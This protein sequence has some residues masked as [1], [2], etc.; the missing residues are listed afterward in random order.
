MT[1]L[2][3]EDKM[4][5][6]NKDKKEIWFDKEKFKSV[7]NQLTK[8]NWFSPATRVE[9]LTYCLEKP[10]TSDWMK[11]VDD[12]KNFCFYFSDVLKTHLYDEKEN[13]WLENPFDDGKFC[14]A[15]FNLLNKDEFH[16]SRNCVLLLE[17]FCLPDIHTNHQNM[18]LFYSIAI[19]TMNLFFTN[20]WNHIPKP[21]NNFIDFLRKQIFLY[22]I[23]NYCT[24]FIN[25][26]LK[27]GLEP[28]KLSS[29]NWIFVQ[30]NDYD[31]Q[32]QN[33][34]VISYLLLFLDKKFKYPFECE[35]NG[36]DFIESAMNIYENMYKT[37]I[38]LPH[39]KREDAIY[40]FFNMF[41]IRFIKHIIYSYREDKTASIKFKHGIYLFHRFCSILRDDEKRLNSVL[42]NLFKIIDVEEDFVLPY[43]NAYGKWN[44]IKLCGDVGK[45][46][47][48][49]KLSSEKSI[50]DLI[51]GQILNYE[52]LLPDELIDK[53]KSHNDKN[54]P[55]LQFD[56]KQEI[57]LIKNKIFYCDEN[58]F[59]E[60]IESI[61]KI[62]GLISNKDG[63]ARKIDDIHLKDFLKL[64]ADNKF[65]LFKYVC[66]LD[67]CYGGVA[68]RGIS[69][70]IPEFEKFIIN[71][72]SVKNETNKLFLSNSN[73]NT[74]IKDHL[75]PNPYVCSLYNLIITKFIKAQTESD[76]LA[77]IVSILLEKFGSIYDLIYQVK[78]IL[79]EKN[80]G[81]KLKGLWDFALDCIL[82]V[83]KASNKSVLSL[84][85]K[86]AN[87][88][89]KKYVGQDVLE[90]GEITLSFV[91]KAMLLIDVAKAFDYDTNI[92]CEGTKSENG[93]SKKTFDLLNKII[94]DENFKL[95]F[96]LD[97]TLPIDLISI[98]KCFEQME[99]LKFEV[100]FYLNDEIFNPNVKQLEEFSPLLKK[101]ADICNE[102]DKTTIFDLIKQTEKFTQKKV[103]KMERINKIENWAKKVKNYAHEIKANNL[104]NKNLFLNQIQTEN[105]K[106]S[107]KANDLLKKLLKQVKIVTGS[108]NVGERGAYLLRS[109]LLNQYFNSLYEIFCMVYDPKQHINL[110]SEYINTYREIISDS[111]NSAIVMKI[112][113]YT[114]SAIMGLNKKN[115]FEKI[116]ELENI[117]IEIIGYII[118]LISPYS[119]DQVIFFKNENGENII[120]NV[121]GGLKQLQENLIDHKKTSELLNTDK[122]LHSFNRFER[123]KDAM[124]FGD[125]LIKKAYRKQERLLNNLYIKSGIESGRSY[126]LLYKEKRQAITD[127]TNLNVFIIRLIASLCT[128]KSID[129]YKLPID[130][131]NSFCKELHD[132]LNMLY[133]L[134][135]G[136]NR[137]SEYKNACK[138]VI[139]QQQKMVIEIS[140]FT[141]DAIR[142]LNE[143]DIFEKVYLPKYEDDEDIDI[144]TIDSII[145]L[146]SNRTQKDII[147][148]KD[149]NDQNITSNIIEEFKL[150]KTNLKINGLRQKFQDCKEKYP[151]YTC[152]L[153]DKA[154]A[155]F[156]DLHDF[157]SIL[158]EPQTKEQRIYTEVL[159]DNKNSQM[160]MLVET[161]N[162]ILNVIKILNSKEFDGKKLKDIDDQII[163][164]IIDLLS[165]DEQKTDIVFFKDEKGENITSD[166]TN[167]LKLLKTNIESYIYDKESK[168]AIEL[169][170]ELK[171]S[172][173]IIR[174]VSAEE[175]N[176][177]FDN[178]YKVLCMIYVP[179]KIDDLKSKYKELYRKT[180]SDSENLELVLTISERLEKLINNLNNQISEYV[181]NPEEIKIETIESI[182]KLF[183]V[184]RDDNVIIFKNQQEAN[185]TS[186]I[187]DKMKKLKKN[188]SQY[189]N[190]KSKLQTSNTNQNKD[191]NKIDT[192]TNKTNATDETKKIL[193]EEND[194]KN[195]IQDKNDTS[196]NDYKQNIENNIDEST[197]KF[198]TIKNLFSNGQNKSAL[199]DGNKRK[200][201][202]SFHVSHNKIKILFNEIDNQRATACIKNK[203]DSIDNVD[204]NNN[205]HENECNNFMFTENDLSKRN[206]CEEV[207][208]EGKK[209]KIETNIK[210]NNVE[211]DPNDIIKREDTNDD[212]SNNTS[213]ATEES[214]NDIENKKSEEQTLISV[215]EFQQN[216]N[217]N[218]R[219]KAESNYQTETNKNDGR[220]NLDTHNKINAIEIENDQKEINGLENEEKK[221][222][223]Q[224][225]NINANNDN[226]SDEIIENIMENINY[227][228]SEFN[229][230]KENDDNNI[231]QNESNKQIEDKNEIK[232]I[233]E[234]N[235]G[236]NIPIKND[237]INNQYEK[238]QSENNNEENSNQKENNLNLD[239]SYAIVIQK[240][241]NNESNFDKS[242]NTEMKRSSSF[243]FK[244]IYRN[245][246]ELSQQKQNIPTTT[247]NNKKKTIFAIIFGIIFVLSAVLL[248]LA[249]TIQALNFLALVISMTVVV[250]VTLIITIAFIISIL[251]RKKMLESLNIKGDLRSRSKS[252]NLLKKDN[253]ININLDNAGILGSV[254]IK[255][256]K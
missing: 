161:S 206:K 177:C 75:F 173:L 18:D 189:I 29:R 250:A 71:Y 66:K 224:N 193:N 229:D 254:H 180:I 107:R 209:N 25:S 56:I 37:F 68:I 247:P 167:G 234:S 16:L 10:V 39:K 129:N 185:I 179:E 186:D 121:V 6:K 169:L 213:G 118:G 116:D 123:V 138:E 249:L 236:I 81:Y 235:N 160:F 43:K 178:L 95:F 252:V 3:G 253:N 8:Q 85:I 80:Y 61:C 181:K 216:H 91:R 220:E 139:D 159:S 150:L 170:T 134:E 87:G 44:F 156:K 49:N 76:E 241:S 204:K 203:V 22:D 242:I 244:K 145:S 171:Y 184:H 59:L 214:Q 218:N 232:Y 5:T 188:L 69:C 231:N 131:V 65:N 182:I 11:T 35:K 113:E 24:E 14:N 217:C 255:T 106:E 215:N 124:L 146:L 108:I 142:F 196:K 126:S 47:I 28:K 38:K 207:K 13:C 83:D 98:K 212:A 211:S 125:Q 60:N 164:S 57:F 15:M 194:D 137:N 199:I 100:L 223:M 201:N 191:E 122:L 198:M 73:N 12:L 208:K 147:F 141:I 32:T 174:K 115:I 79:A 246:T 62:F 90:E 251:Q 197:N 67:S 89:F 149:E 183:S 202:Q 96:E 58:K 154:N 70:L 111:Y 239:G 55:K 157:L 41:S 172:S 143:K 240:K 1:I 48:A 222:K 200:R 33:N 120:S 136:K 140:K 74:F 45:N 135:D 92:F 77:D 153:T 93:T 187:F 152:L 210:I 9:A 103:S 163:G 219:N 148:F 243:S 162:I 64:L 227:E 50:S 40:D 20:K 151:E 54:K 112:S 238:K 102:N 104:A 7:Q 132:F 2:G 133:V 78:D 99:N 190:D 226:T 26:K 245:N 225:I 88:S 63:E 82:Y 166:I 168:K 237:D 130:T 233:N 221:D 165:N 72:H 175:I 195:T 127:L 17:N 176:K 21:S 46:Y 110:N 19:N 94:E 109:D 36:L 105:E 4:Q 256:I 23:E 31:I 158:K 117:D 27:S 192:D 34:F 228:N 101:C 97:K 51:N 30:A 42:E 144:E 86:W 119:N 155:C 114:V 84:L 53:M 52:E 248:I 205:E 230:K 128:L